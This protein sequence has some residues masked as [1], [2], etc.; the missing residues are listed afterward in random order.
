MQEKILNCENAYVNISCGQKNTNFLKG[1]AYFGFLSYNVNSYKIFWGSQMKKLA[2]FSDGWRNFFN[3]SWVDGCHQYIA[4]HQLD[5]QVYVF[6]SFGD[7]SVDEKF[8][9]GEYNIFNLPDLKAFDGII[10]DLNNIQQDAVRENFLWKLRNSGVPTISLLDEIPGLY[11]AGIDNYAAMYTIVEHVI[12][13]HGCKEINF[14][15]GPTF[16][17]ESKERLR[18]YKA[19]LED[20]GIRYEE[21]RV[22]CKDYTIT[23]GKEG[24]EYFVKKGN[25]PEAFICANDNI[26]V[27]LCNVAKI[28]GYRVP[29]DLI[30]TGF[31]NLDKASYYDPK[32][33]TA[34]F[35]RGE[36]AQKA[37]ELMHHIWEGQTDVK[38]AY[39][40]VTHIFQDS[41][42][43]KSN[44]TVNLGKYV[45]DHI[46]NEDRDVRMDSAMM[47]L[48]RELLECQSF[49][50]M[51]KRL[52]KH[53][54]RLKCDAIYMMVNDEIANCQD[55]VNATVQGEVPK[56]TVGY[57]DE[58]VVAMS[59][60]NGQIVSNMA[61][62]ESQLLPA[63]DVPMS[64]DIYVF[65]PLHFRDQE[66]GYLVFKNCDYMLDS[67]LIFEILNV[68]L[69]SME[70]MYH[71]LMLSNLNEELSQLYV[72]DSLTGLYNRMAYNRYAVPMFQRCMENQESLLVMFL[73]VDR[74]KYI[75]DTFGHDAGNVAIK[76]IAMAAASQV[77]E[78]GIV[79]RY[80][81][82]EFVV[83][84]PNVNTEQAEDIVKCIHAHIAKVSDALKLGFDI[85]ASIGYVVASDAKRSL[86]DYINDAD[87]KMYD[88]KHAHHEEVNKNK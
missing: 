4:D 14:V 33:T 12:K 35:E 63:V 61:D 79:I 22:F 39:A 44:T 5:A 3:F 47:E 24:F 38:A 23:T 46:M 37:M 8:N 49:K 81:G 13:E 57:P 20:N 48:K 29:E 51:G 26:A 53:L 62:K 76:T 21:D 72:L 74:L 54:E 77:P 71:R 55:Y 88:I 2:I 34:G 56:R 18:A 32:I 40:G 19:A 9:A 67:Q 80:G 52:P 78:D 6:N 59:Y 30:V 15:G 1:V 75:N 25:L 68:L 27:G 58:L 73:D 70:N 50:E 28:E 42:G 65:S 43:C 36:I 86:A 16:N 82:D 17:H 10:V 31:D 69:E 64:E 87:E 84:A 41:C 83:L 11:Y 85:M 66:V 7:F 60:V 45:E